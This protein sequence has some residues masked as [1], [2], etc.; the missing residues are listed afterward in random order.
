M[1]QP[2]GLF[3]AVVALVLE[4]LGAARAAQQRSDSSP[5]ACPLAVRPL[6]CDPVK[7]EQ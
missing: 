1:R 3:S 2:L 4:V 7:R 6:A 5:R